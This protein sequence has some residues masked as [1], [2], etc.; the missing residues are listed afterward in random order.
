MLIFFSD[1]FLI[2]HLA[3]A[4]VVYKIFYMKRE[5]IFWILKVRLFSAF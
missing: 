2:S 4:D 5:E 3:A 1:L